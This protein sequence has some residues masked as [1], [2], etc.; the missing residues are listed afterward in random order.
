MCLDPINICIIENVQ[1]ATLLWIYLESLSRFIIAVVDFCYNWSFK[2]KE[3][4]LF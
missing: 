1:V 4:L 2:S 3:I